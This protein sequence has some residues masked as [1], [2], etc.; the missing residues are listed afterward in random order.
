MDSSVFDRQNKL[1]ISLKP[2]NTHV[3]GK[4]EKFYTKI[5]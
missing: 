5:N 3:K 2:D 4:R 1:E